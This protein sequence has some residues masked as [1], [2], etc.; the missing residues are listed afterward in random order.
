MGWIEAVHLRAYSRL[1]RD[2]AV[3]AFHQLTA[4]DHEKD[5]GGIELFR[6]IALDNDLCVCIHW[7]GEAP[8]RGKSNLGLQL[9]AAFSEF[10]QINYSVWTREGRV[11]SKARSTHGKGAI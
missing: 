8:R 3:S 6:D 2:E 9:A 4:P 10:G 1:E 11:A 7:R 5:L